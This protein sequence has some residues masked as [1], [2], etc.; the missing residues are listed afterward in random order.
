MLGDAV[1]TSYLQASAKKR[2]ANNGVPPW[3]G[4]QLVACIR[5]VV[6]AFRMTAGRFLMIYAAVFA[7]I[8]FSPQTSQ[9]LQHTAA[10]NTA[11]IAAWLLAIVGHLVMAGYRAR[12]ETL[13]INLEATGVNPL[14]FAPYRIPRGPV[15]FIAVIYYLLS[16][17]LNVTIASL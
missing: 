14:L 5:D 16:A 4:E 17:A 12:V 9:L 2:S 1:T 8:W 7:L 10:A 3:A 6:A 15:I 13:F 11:V